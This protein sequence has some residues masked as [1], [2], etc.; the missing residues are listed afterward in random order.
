VDLFREQAV[1]TEA[2]GGDEV[3]QP[4]IGPAVAVG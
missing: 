4:R 2:L 3:A 1:L